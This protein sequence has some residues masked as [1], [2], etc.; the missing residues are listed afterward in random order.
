MSDQYTTTN[1]SN[2]PSF[3]RQTSAVDHDMQVR[4]M[5]VYNGGTGFGPA[6]L[7]MMVF[8]VVAVLASVLTNFNTNSLSGVD[9]EAAQIDAPANS[10]TN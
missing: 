5:P 3:L 10:S 2:Y 1:P 4:Q 7:V 9:G 8:V 6:L